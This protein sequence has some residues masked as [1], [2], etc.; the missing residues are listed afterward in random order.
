MLA[1]VINDAGVQPAGLA[2]RRCDG[3]DPMTLL[4]GLLLLLGAAG[5]DSD[6]DG[7]ANADDRCPFFAGSDQTDRDGDRVG[8][9]CQCGDA[10]GDGRVDVSDIVSVN[11]MVEG[12]R[13]ASPLCDANLVGPD[14][15]QRCE[16]SD[17]RAINGAIFQ[18]CFPVCGRYPK[19]PE[20]RSACTGAQP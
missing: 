8:D 6:G 7:I 18:S 2:G 10:N 3:G 15:K 17:I 13:P 9:A 19:P 1:G 11:L 20:G 14:D 4:L 12:K 5:G 16:S